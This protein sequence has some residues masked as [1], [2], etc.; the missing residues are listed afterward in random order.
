MFL[1]LPVIRVE[2]GMITVARSKVSTLCSQPPLPVRVER[3]AGDLGV[4]L[5]SL[6]GNEGAIKRIEPRTPL[7][8]SALVTASFLDGTVTVAAQASS[9]PNPQ[10]GGAATGI[11]IYEEE[12]PVTE[13]FTLSYLD[14]S[15]DDWERRLPRLETERGR[16]LGTGRSSPDTVRP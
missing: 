3:I 13:P 9:A 12:L 4:G 5:D 2:F 6:V 15:S 8:T 14:A 10:P 16:I 7:A 1:T 11:F